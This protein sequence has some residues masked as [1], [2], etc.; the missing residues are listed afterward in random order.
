MKQVSLIITAVLAG[1]ATLAGAASTTSA[2]VTRTFNEVRLLPPGAPPAPANPGDKISGSTGVATGDQSRAELRFPDNTLT[3][4]GANSVFRLEPGQRSME[5]EEG[6]ILLQVPKQL[7]GARVRTAAVTAAVTGTTLL[8]EYTPNGYIKL[9][10]VEGEV[11]L[12][13]NDKP[14]NFTTLKAGQMIIMKPDAKSFPMPV[15]VDLKRLARTSKLM[16]ENLFGP[17]GNLKQIG[18]ALN[19]QKKLQK[20]GELTA[21]AFVI[22]GRGTLVTLTREASA[23]IARTAGLAARPAG[24]GGAGAGV[25]AGQP[26]AGLLPPIIIGDPINIP[27][28]TGTTFIDEDTSIRTNLSITAFNESAMNFQ[29]SDGASYNPLTD[30]P[31]LPLLGGEREDAAMRALYRG[32]GKWAVFQFDALQIGGTPKVD[33]A[34]G[35]RNL[36]L[37]AVSG[38]QFYDPYYSE[39][40]NPGTFTIGDDLDSLA[41]LT[42][43]GNIVMDTNTRIN[44]TGSLLILDA[45]GAGSN[46]VVNGSGQF[47]W[48][49]YGDE[50]S[51]AL[52]AGRAVLRAAQDVLV[53]GAS[54]VAASVDINARR[55]VN[56]SSVSGIGAL[57]RVRITAGR[58]VN[59]TGGTTIFVGDSEELWLLSQTGPASLEVLAQ[60]GSITMDGVSVDAGV[61]DLQS[62]RG[63]IT[64]AN[65]VMSA[66]AIKARTLA[67]DGT[68]VISG[69]TLDASNLI[70]LYANGSNGSVRFTGPS[71]SLS[72]GLIDIAGKTVT[73]DAGTQVQVNGNLR[74]FTD[75]AQF[76]NAGATGRGTF[77][78]MESTPVE[79]NKRT[80]RERPRF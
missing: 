14:S 40:P 31:I 29:T 76:S 78:D 70:R 23:Q 75:N 32:A 65:T 12:Y 8:L 33:S 77:V 72:A 47:E 52:R 20:N 80:F 4:L 34:S 41:V 19:D 24:G 45:F 39:A 58:N 51:I 74:V 67:P 3:R 9:I 46:V 13:F 26:G 68:I 6:V 10:V 62:Q 44:G 5:L 21:S 7:G 64:L 56:V 2:T 71:S 50:H 37:A 53:N 28:I 43:S 16:D 42:G 30:G 11:D 49:P 48:S 25:S 1:C 73:I 69:S 63:N 61:I 18:D 36:L 59:I 22:E 17:L 57:D 15:K 27:L 35:V 79:V 55:D 38:A 60:N 66:D 54:I